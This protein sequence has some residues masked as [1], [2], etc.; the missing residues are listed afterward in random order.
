MAN[1]LLSPQAQQSLVQISQYTLDNF[2]ERQKKSYLKNAAGS[3]ARYSYR[4]YR[5]AAPVDGTQNTYWLAPLVLGC[6]MILVSV[7][8]G[9]REVNVKDLAAAELKFENLRILKPEQILKGE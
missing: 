4:G 5:R 2:S 6:G 7:L 8:S 1:Y 9:A 3:Y